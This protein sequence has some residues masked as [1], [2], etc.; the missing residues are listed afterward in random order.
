MKIVL[1]SV[2]LS[3]QVI[4]NSHHQVEELKEN[5]MIIKTKNSKQVATKE[6]IHNNNPSV[7]YKSSSKDVSH[8][9]ME[10]IHANFS[11]MVTFLSSSAKVLS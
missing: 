4:A 2:L 10:F 1:D 8:N 11:K 3:F 5:E 7:L 9:E 6:N